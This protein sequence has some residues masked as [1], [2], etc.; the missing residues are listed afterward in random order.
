MHNRGVNFAIKAVRSE[1]VR[2]VSCAVCRFRFFASFVNVSILLTMG[3]SPPPQ[4]QLSVNWT[5]SS[6]SAPWPSPEKST[7]VISNKPD[8]KTLYQRL[9]ELLLTPRVPLSGCSVGFASALNAS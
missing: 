1:T 6:F 5:Q 3:Y 9:L 7:P 8:A 2:G 4:I